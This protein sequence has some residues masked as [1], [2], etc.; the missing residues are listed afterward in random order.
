MCTERFCM[1][2]R[3]R[4]GFY[5]ATFALIVI[6]GAVLL[7]LKAQVSEKQVKADLS[8]LQEKYVKLEGEADALT[9]LNVNLQKELIDAKDLSRKWRASAM[10]AIM[11][12]QFEFGYDGVTDASELAVS[13]TPEYLD[14]VFD[15]C[16]W[17]IKPEPCRTYPKDAIVP[18]VIDVPDYEAKSS[19]SKK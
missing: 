4:V 2:F 3:E 6:F 5:L 19:K 15:P 17:S 10:P 14:I 1:S 13:A 18:I 9:S 12:Y 7:A 8:A 16:H 11:S